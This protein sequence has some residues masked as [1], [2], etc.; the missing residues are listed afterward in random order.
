MVQIKASSIKNRQ[1]H[2]RTEKCTKDKTMTTASPEHTAQI[3]QF[4][5]GGL[6]GRRDF[7]A[8]IEKKAVEANPALCDL[9]FGGGWYHAEAIKDSAPSAGKPS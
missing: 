9:A 8:R 2:I 4:P 5:V 6:R 3:I 7:M 1:K